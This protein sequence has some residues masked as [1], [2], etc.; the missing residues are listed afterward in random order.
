MG[1]R[2]EAMETWCRSEFHDDILPQI[3]VDIP[4]GEELRTLGVG[5]GSGKHTTGQ[6][7]HK[8]VKIILKLLNFIA[9]FGITIENAFK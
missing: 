8:I 1:N 7:I 2:V 4:D 9:I 5:S 6:K 3:N